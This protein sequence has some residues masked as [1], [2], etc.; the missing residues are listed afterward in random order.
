MM[1]MQPLCLIHTGMEQAPTI[2]QEM[3]REQRLTVILQDQTTRLHTTSFLMSGM[4]SH[5]L[6]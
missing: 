3:G 6:I 1:E 4:L 2:T 5:H